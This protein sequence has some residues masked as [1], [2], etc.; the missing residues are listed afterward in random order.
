MVQLLLNLLLHSLYC[1]TIP[2]FFRLW[3]ETRAHEA[4]GKFN[5]QKMLT[6]I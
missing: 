6:K 3:L 4:G 1:A 2:N 5:L